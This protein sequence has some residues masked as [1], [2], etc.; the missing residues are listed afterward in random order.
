MGGTMER[1]I[2]W[3]LA[4]AA[5]VIATASSI[6]A[7]QN[8]RATAQP[9]LNTNHYAV[10]LASGQAFFGKIENLHAEYVVLQEVFYIQSRTNPETKQVSNVLVK[11]GQE[12]HSPDRMIVSK[13]HVMLIE[14]V[15]E[16]S[17]VAKLIA[18]QSK[19]SVPAP[20]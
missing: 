3:L 16:G 1:P 6:L 19:Q 12:W 5:V 2:S 20:K 13:R 15:T 8:W 10:L 18:D 4:L 11:R 9:P 17:Q 14:P 7:Y